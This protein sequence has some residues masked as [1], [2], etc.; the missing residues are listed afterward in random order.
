MLILERSEFSIDRGKLKIHNIDWRGQYIGN[1]NL[2]IFPKS[3]DK[4]SKIL[5]FLSTKRNH[6]RAPRREH[7]ISWWFSS[8]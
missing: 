8:M 3:V 2:L 5:K 1:S 6:S 4:L 7:W